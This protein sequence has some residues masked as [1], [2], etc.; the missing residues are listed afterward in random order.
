M[1]NRDPPKP[2]ILKEAS[3]DMLAE[4]PIFASIFHQ[5]F[6]FYHVFSGTAPGPHFLSFFPEFYQ[7]SAIWDPAL[8]PSWL[9]NAT[10]NRPNGLKMTS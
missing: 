5:K 3:S 10:Q 2:H 1:K 4:P 7:K 6:L 8:A 9:P